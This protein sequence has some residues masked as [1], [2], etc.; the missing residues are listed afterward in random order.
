M[1]L[2]TGNSTFF[3]SIST[4][5]TSSGD[6]WYKMFIIIEFVSAALDLRDVTLTNRNQAI[7]CIIL[8][9]ALTCYFEIAVLKGCVGRG[10]GINKLSGSAV[11]D[12][13]QV[14]SITQSDATLTLTLNFYAIEGR[15][16][17]G[18]DEQRIVVCAALER[19]VSVVG[20]EIDFLGDCRSVD[21]RYVGDFGNVVS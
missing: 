9:R 19:V 8:P 13:R 1:P 3:G 15:F 20:D 18:E 12:C 10:F 21:A 11:R 6:A 17:A 5:F 16:H 14:V 2:Y 4:S 7:K